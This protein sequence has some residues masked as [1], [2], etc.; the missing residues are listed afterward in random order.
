M[1]EAKEI[2]NENAL[3]IYPHL[4]KEGKKKF[5]QLYPEFFMENFGY[6]AACKKLGFDP[7]EK[8]PFKNPTDK[9]EKRANANMKLDIQREAIGNHPGINA[10]KHFPVFKQTASGL[11]FSFTFYVL[12]DSY[13]FAFVGAPFVFCS[14]EEAADF[15]KN[16]EDLY[17]EIFTR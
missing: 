2:T 9:F 3:E 4:D 6:E 13:S 11:V 8:L 1:K 15:G 16:N 5:K 17:T 12:W 7:V 10:A 14:S